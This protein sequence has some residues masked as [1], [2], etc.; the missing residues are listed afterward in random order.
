ML[1]GIQRGSRLRCVFLHGTWTGA[2]RASGLGSPVREEFPFRSSSADA[3]DR[4]L[5]HSSPAQQAS[6]CR[7]RRAFVSETLLSS[8]D[9][10]LRWFHLGFH[11]GLIH[12][13]SSLRRLNHSNPCTFFRKRRINS[14]ARVRQQGQMNY[15]LL[16]CGTDG[17]QHVVNH[18]LLVAND[19]F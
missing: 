7:R 3:L 19:T 12:S 8:P 6:L 16:C 11:L 5:C 15:Y 13:D 9:L 14:V 1:H 4:A 10:A 17:D 2:Q 18:S